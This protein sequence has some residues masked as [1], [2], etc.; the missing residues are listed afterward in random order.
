MLLAIIP[1]RSG[2]KGIKNKNIKLFCGKPLIQWSIEAALNTLEFQLRELNSG[3]IPRGL[4]LMLSINPGWLYHDQPF[5]Y[6]RYNS[7]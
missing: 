1:A 2:S 4:A 6:I 5:E 3:G 7:I